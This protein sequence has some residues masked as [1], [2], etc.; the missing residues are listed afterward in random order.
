MSYVYPGQAFDHT[1]TPL[2]GWY[3]ES[4]LD[5]EVALSSNVNIGS[6]AIPATAGIC[7]HAT[8]HGARSPYEVYGGAMTGPQTLIVELGC[9][10]THG[11]PMFLWTN[12]TDPDVYN[13]GVI[14]GVPAYG[15]TTYPADFYSVFPPIA[16]STVPTNLVALVA[17]G[18]Y[19][20][21]T[22]EYDADQTYASGQPLRAVTSNTDT[23]GG[24]LTNQKG[25]TAAYN[26]AGVVQ[27]VGN[28]ATVTNW[29]TIVGWVSRETYTNANRRTSL[30][31]WPDLVP[32]NR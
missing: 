8:D 12:S 22:T 19:E 28:T 7:V 11:M 21:E 14:S 30:A 27:F 13:P 3:R 20:L 25:T 18:G 32:G 17:S 16:G 23:N 2:K 10:P 24:R 26:S 5:A 31:F 29:D 6:A 15:N 4:A 1:L 9:G